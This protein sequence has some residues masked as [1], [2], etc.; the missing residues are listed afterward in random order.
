M[1][2][3][4]EFNSKAVKNGPEIKTRTGSLIMITPAINESF[5]IARVRVSEKQAV[6]AFPK[7]GLIG[8]GFQKE[9]QDWNT[10]LPHSEPAERIFRHIKINK[11]VEGDEPPSDETCIEAIKLLS[12]TIDK[13]LA[14]SKAA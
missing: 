6:V 12:S 9:E 10:N 8:V 5:W 4:V 2:L 1:N 14:K 7:F 13:V 3:E 11:K